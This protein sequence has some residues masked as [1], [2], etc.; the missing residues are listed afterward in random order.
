MTTE[1]L[2]EKWVKKSIKDH[3]LFKKYDEYYIVT[4]GY[5]AFKIDISNEKIVNIIKEHTFQSLES[6][7]NI[8]NKK[9]DFKEL[10]IDLTCKFDITDKME[11][12]KTSFIYDSSEYRMRIF[13]NQNEKIFLNENLLKYIN[14]NEYSLYSTNPISPM[15]FYSENF[16]CLMLPVRML[17]FPYEIKLK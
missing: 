2:F 16:S 10:K 5:M 17:D 12:E 13:A 4:D 6:N 1:K 9:I 11:T 15:I 14:V 7:F 3:F 8:I